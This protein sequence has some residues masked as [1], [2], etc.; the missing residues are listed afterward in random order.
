[1][2]DDQFTSNVRSID[3][4][5]PHDLNAFCALVNKAGEVANLSPD[6]VRQHGLKLV[7]VMK[8]NI[9]AAVGA[10][11]KPDPGYHQACFQKAGVQDQWPLYPVEVGWL[12]CDK[13]YRGGMGY[14]V[15]DALFAEPE[16]RQPIYGTVRTDNLVALHVIGKRGFK[17]IGSPY[18]SKEHPEAEIQLLV[19]AGSG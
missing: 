4:C 14:R 2:A 8:Q 16:G 6:W 11:K 3:A 9:L 15:L 18:R 12:H 19:R 7:F 10:L 13:A 17:P 1:M 5:S